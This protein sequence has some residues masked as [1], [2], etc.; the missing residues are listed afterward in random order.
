MFAPLVVLAAILCIWSTVP[1][2]QTSEAD[3]SEESYA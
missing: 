1:G 3:Q 2:G